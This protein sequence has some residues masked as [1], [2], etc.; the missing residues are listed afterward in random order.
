MS[1]A[2]G[3]GFALHVVPTFGDEPLGDDPGGAWPRFLAAAPLDDLVLADRDVEQVAAGPLRLLLTAAGARAFAERGGAREHRFVVSLDGARLYAGRIA[4]VATA[5]P[6]RH[7]VIHVDDDGLSTLVVVLPELGARADSEVTAPPALLAHFAADG[8][9]LPPG[10]SP[11]PRY[12]RRSF[13][14]ELSSPR[15][16]AVRVAAGS[17]DGRCSLD[18]ALARPGA[19]AGI[20]DPHARADLDCA[21]FEELWKIVVRDRIARLQPA[22][23]RGRT[24]VVPIHPPHIR[25]NLFA[26]RGDGAPITVDASWTSPSSSDSHARAFL[27]GVAALTHRTLPGVSLR[28][29]MP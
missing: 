25:I 21:D 23:G 7:P 4:F 5:R 26:D 29:F 18:A 3:R 1:T 13:A 19:A 6:L 22:A 14:V 24:T 2:H 12:R 10:T 11:A 20:F 27:R 9:L 16:Q 17:L 15:E 8:R 28:R